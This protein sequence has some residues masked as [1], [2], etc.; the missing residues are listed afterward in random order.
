VPE[1][2]SVEVDPADG[3]VTVFP[4]AGKHILGEVQELLE[5]Q[6]VQVEELQLER[7]RLDDVFRRITEGGSQ[8][9]AA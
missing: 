5:A 6:R 3:R 9:K 7:G 4:R 1:V 2:D 8:V